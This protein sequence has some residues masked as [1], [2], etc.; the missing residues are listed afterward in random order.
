MRIISELISQIADLVNEQDEAVNRIVEDVRHVK[1][2]ADEGQGDLGQAVVYSKKGLKRRCCMLL[3]ILLGAL[4]L[5]A[6]IL[7]SILN[8]KG[9][10]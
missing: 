7:L 8:S 4:V 2:L 10:L 6:P 1:D 5:F 3:L 9:V